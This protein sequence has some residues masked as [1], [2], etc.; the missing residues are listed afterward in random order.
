MPLVHISGRDLLKRSFDIGFAFVK[1][2]TRE[3]YQNA[4]PPLFSLYKSNSWYPNVI[5]V[6]EEFA[7]YAT[8][9]LRNFGVKAT[10]RTESSHAA[11]KSQLRNRKGDLHDLH[12]D[13]KD[14]LEGQKLFD[15]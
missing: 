9:A 15:Y 14:M 7:I 12:T 11:I 8:Q 6:R 13:I 2:E 5:G 10:A 1:A 4:L 3:E